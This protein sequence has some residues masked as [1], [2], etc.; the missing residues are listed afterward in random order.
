MRISLEGYD[1]GKLRVDQ[2]CTALRHDVACLTDAVRVHDY[3]K[4]QRMTAI[5]RERNQIIRE[6]MRVQ[7]LQRER[8]QRYHHGIREA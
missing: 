1:G 6:R 2:H 8:T 3:A 7:Q 4:I 5:I